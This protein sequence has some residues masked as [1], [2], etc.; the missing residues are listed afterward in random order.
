VRMALLFLLT[1]GAAEENTATHPA[2]EVQK[3]R[4]AHAAQG[5]KDPSYASR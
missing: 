2:A 3:L 5:Q 1:A 4:E